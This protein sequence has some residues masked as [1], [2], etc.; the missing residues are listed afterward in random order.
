MRCAVSDR[1]VCFVSYGISKLLRLTLV[2]GVYEDYRHSA[3]YLVS[4]GNVALDSAYLFMRVFIADVASLGKRSCDYR[5]QALIV[6][7]YLIGISMCVTDHSADNMLYRVADILCLG[8]ILFVLKRYDSCIRNKIR[9]RLVIH[10]NIF[11]SYIVVLR[12]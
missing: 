6:Y 10:S 3:C 5:D 4:L 9:G 7:P 12:K 2:L 11:I 1:T 8:V